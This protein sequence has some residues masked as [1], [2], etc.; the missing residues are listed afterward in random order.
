MSELDSAQR[1]RCAV[2]RLEASHSRAP[3]LDSAMI[4]LNQI[5][6]VLAAP[7][8][9]ELPFRV[10]TAKKSK[11]QVALLVAIERYLAWPPR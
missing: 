4:L 5:I 1:D 8:L 6:Q 10:L 2:E 9:N 3:A 11:G 7:H